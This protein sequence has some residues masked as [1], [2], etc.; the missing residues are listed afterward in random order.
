LIAGLFNSKPKIEK[1]EMEALSILDEIVSIKNDHLIQLVTLMNEKVNKMDTYG[2]VLRFSEAAAEKIKEYYGGVLKMDDKTLR[3]EL[4]YPGGKYYKPVEVL[5]KSGLRLLGS[6]SNLSEEEAS[7][8]LVGCMTLADELIMTQIGNLKFE[9]G[10]IKVNLKELRWLTFNK[11]NSWERW[12]DSKLGRETRNI[13][14]DTIGLIIFESFNN[15]VNQK[16]KTD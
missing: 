2:Y 6:N 1:E 9:D 16:S 11:R 13:N 14:S 5:N 7:V 15:L 10:I 8:L 4:E 3:F 12:L